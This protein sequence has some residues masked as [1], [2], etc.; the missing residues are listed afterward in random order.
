MVACGGQAI[1]RM[2]RKEC[3]GPALMIATSPPPGTPMPA[4]Q[5]AAQPHAHPR[6][7]V[8]E[9]VTRAVLKVLKPPAQRA[10]EI[11][12]DDGERLSPVPWGF[13]AHGVLELRDWEPRSK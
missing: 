6:I 12:D 9:G 5:N 3:I 7:E 10:I 8:D 11:V 13:G 4:T 2:R 1:E